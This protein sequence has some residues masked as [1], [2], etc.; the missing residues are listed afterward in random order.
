[1]N[2]PTRKIA[3][4]KTVALLCV[5]SLLLLCLAN[6]TLAA[7]DQDTQST[8]LLH[9]GLD[10]FPSFLAAD[11]HITD[12][13]D[14]NGN[15]VLYIVHHNDKRTAQKVAARLREIKK[16]KG[17]P[18]KVVIVR[19]DYDDFQLQQPAGIFIAQPNLPHLA[20]VVNYGKQK[21]I[22]TFSPFVGD[23][24]LGVA[25]SIA[26]T[27]RILPQVNMATLADSNLDLKPFFLRIASRYPEAKTN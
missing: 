22:I 7:Q 11:Q 10:L 3:I 27:A 19:D 16:I 15:L 4:F 24:T 20:A 21:S 25:G 23:V 8:R 13:L 18:L 9:A 6:T 12:K 14:K 17:T 2:L 1:M 26:V 5:I